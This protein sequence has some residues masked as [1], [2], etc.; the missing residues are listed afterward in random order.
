[1]SDRVALSRPAEAVALL[2]LDTA[3]IGGFVSWDAVD[4]LADR[5]EEARAGGARVAVLASKFDGHWFEHAW[6]PDLWKTVQGEETSGP[7][8][9]WFRALSEL[10]SPE[11]VTIAA[12]SGDC[13]GGGAELGWACDLRVA[14]EQATFSQP[15]V[16]LGLPTGIGGTSRLARLVGRTVA[17][18][19]V[20]GGA[21][22]AAR[23]IY[24]LGGVNR[25][26]PTG[27]AVSESVKWARKLAERPAAA[28][29]ALK[30]ILNDNDD[31]TLSDALQNEQAIFQ[32]VAGTPQALE[33]MKKT[34]ARFD[35]GESIRA[36]YGSAGS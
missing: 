28:L 23:R 26:V 20:L 12:V 18:E 8:T 6:L 1:M 7:A 11:L 21:P 22:V 30:Q 35:A 3:D 5:L 29:A 33:R 19:M 31:R 36:V 16:L 34:Q 17:A 32:S 13:S 14:E 25:V 15:E 4:A 9:G 2:E 24:E 10:A 27:R